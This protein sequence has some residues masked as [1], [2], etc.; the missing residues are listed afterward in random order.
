M[1]AW[2]NKKS[3]YFCLK[4]LT[5]K[6]FIAK[7]TL[8]KNYNINLIIIYMDYK[9]SKELLLD[10]KALTEQQAEAI[11]SLWENN[12]RAYYDFLRNENASEQLK[13]YLGVSDD[14]VLNHEFLP[15]KKQVPSVSIAEKFFALDDEDIIDH[16]IKVLNKLSVKDKDNEEFYAWPYM[17]SKCMSHMAVANILSL[18]SDWRYVFNFEE[19][20]RG[21]VFDGVYRRLG[22]DFLQDVFAANSFNVLGWIHFSYKYPQDQFVKHILMSQHCLATGIGMEVVN[23]KFYICYR[24][25]IAKSMY[26]L[27]DRTLG[28]VKN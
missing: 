24:L 21:T 23:R 1:I 26:E 8:L 16:F 11:L 19:D 3:R 6:F 22:S 2:L 10:T 27:E 12:P 17:T 28:Y 15:I 18:I 25:D 9:T 4:I 13:I 7:R 14:D 5:D 20:E